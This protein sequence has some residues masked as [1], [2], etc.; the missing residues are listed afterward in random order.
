MLFITG[1]NP[2]FDYVYKKDEVFRICY[3]ILV[4]NHCIQMVYFMFNL[5]SIYVKMI[6]V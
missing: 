1:F 4:V 2:V 6:L 5:C 3:Q